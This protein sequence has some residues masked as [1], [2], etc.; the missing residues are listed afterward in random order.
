[1][2]K[3]SKLFLCFQLQ[4]HW[5]RFCF[6]GVIL[7]EVSQRN[8]YFSDQPYGTWFH[9]QVVDMFYFRSGKEACLDIVLRKDFTFNAIL[10]LIWQFQREE[11]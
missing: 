11:F 10:L 6:Y 3:E 5:D 2:R 4:A 7:T 9:G 1:M 8:N